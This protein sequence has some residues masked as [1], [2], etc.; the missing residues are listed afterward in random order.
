MVSDES[1]LEYYMKGFK[2]EL[3]GT[4]STESDNALENRAYMFGALD[5]MTEDGGIYPGC[6]SDE[7]IL[8]KIKNNG[9]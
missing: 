1:L 2:D 5:A 3:R 4:S 9:A 6:E 8:Y 7:K